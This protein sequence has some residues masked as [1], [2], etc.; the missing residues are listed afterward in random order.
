MRNT[1]TNFQ[2]QNFKNEVYLTLRNK[3]LYSLYSIVKVGFQGL[4]LE[5]IIESESG[6]AKVQQVNMF[7]KLLKVFLILQDFGQCR[8]GTSRPC[9]TTQ[10]RS[11]PCLP[12]FHQISPQRTVYSNWVS[13]TQFK[14]RC[15]KLILYDFM[16]SKLTAYLSVGIYH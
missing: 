8:F 4:D 11:C 12:H 2:K 15:I 5:S 13:I 16:T 3:S 10:Q 7:Q 14:L 1:I 6:K 9:S